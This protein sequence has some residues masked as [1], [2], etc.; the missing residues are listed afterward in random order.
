MSKLVVSK[1]IHAKIDRPAGVIS[2]QI[3]K[4]ANQILNDWSNDIN[5]LLGLI[6]KTCH[7]ISKEVKKMSMEA[8]H[9]PNYY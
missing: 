9:Q 8:L 6:E 5:S 3:N 2:F 7:L 4:T 1:T